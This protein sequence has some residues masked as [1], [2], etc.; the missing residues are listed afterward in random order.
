MVQDSDFDI[1]L[2]GATGFTG[3]LV[4]EHLARRQQDQ[5]LRW[6]MAGRSLRKLEHVRT[7]LEL[8]GDFP[9]IEADA[10]DP[11]SLRKMV[12]RTRLVIST[13]G[14]YQLYGAALIAA[15]AETGTD[16]LDLCGEPA[17]MRQMIDA[18]HKTAQKT[19]ARIVFSCGFDSIPFDLAVKTLQGHVKARYGRTAPRI[20]GRVR[21]LKGSYS[22]GTAASLKAS[23]A[24]ASADPAI[25]ALLRN[26]FALTPGFAGVLQPDG[27]SPAYDEALGSW[28]APFVM[29]AIN[30]RNIHR[31]NALLEHPY[32]TNF[33]YDEMLLTGPGEEGKALAETVANSDPL[34]SADGRKPGE[35][36]DKAERESGYYDLLF[37]ALMPDGNSLSLS[38]YGERD[39]GYG[40][41]SRILAESA[42]CLLHEDSDAKGG[43]LTPGAVFGEALLT[44]LAEHAGLHF[45]LD[46]SV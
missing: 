12:G 14:P 42:L 3:K 27:N 22:G 9:L 13:V 43:V 40:S 39:P 15:C 7:S 41:T 45:T 17:F 33:V 20:K 25:R 6:A 10:T 11:D 23:L 29:A 34:A 36:P 8:S 32:G 31:T 44:R 21:A 35:G 38:V 30:T 1:I 26:P 24:A 19:G 18:H 28:A 2:Y 5:K 37:V 46:A 16:Y 4:A